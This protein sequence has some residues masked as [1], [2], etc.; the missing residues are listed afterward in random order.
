MTHAAL[1]AAARDAP[2]HRG[3]PRVLIDAYF[4]DRPYGFGRYVRELV[5]ALD[6]WCRD[7]DFV[8][9]APERVVP[10]LERLSRR[11]T[12]VPLERATFP[13]W[14]QLV[15]PRVASTYHCDLVHFPYQSSAI[16][17][18]R[19]A[20]V[21]TVHDLM[22]LDPSLRDI[23]AVDLIAHLYRR[24]VFELHTKHARSVVA[25][26][27]MTRCELADKRKVAASVVP[28]VCEAFVRSTASVEPAA[29]EGRFF[30][31]R[32]HAGPHKNTR[33]VLESF[34]RV[35]AEG[36]DVRLLVYGGPVPAELLRGVA[37]DGVTPLGAVSDDRL[38][39]LYKAALG[40]IVPSL[41]EGFGL[42]LIE[43]MGFGAPVVTSDLSPMKD[44]ALDAALLVDPRST[45]SIT[46]AL[47]RL[48]HEPSLRSHL[49][50]RGLARYENYSS[51][52]VAAQLGA[53]Y[54]SALAPEVTPHVA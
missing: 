24:V 41:E 26:S 6:T 34:A 39:S 23:S 16:R 28:N 25:V 53:I 20:S 29:R 38:A 10:T 42:S 33:R 4:A 40:V 7:F 18:S 32:G 11:A 31:H 15:I 12:I 19:R 47:R 1:A 17:W 3:L 46:E 50:D 21:A 35:R 44:I 14:E 54:R 2:D 13:L 52:R 5:S 22:F 49:I 30:L 27:E 43:A 8:L 45:D 51:K 36:H 48:M 37:G 9:A